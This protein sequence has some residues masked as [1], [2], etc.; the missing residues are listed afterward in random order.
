MIL[1]NNTLT[2]PIGQGEVVIF[3]DTLYFDSK[4]P[5]MLREVQEGAK[6]IGG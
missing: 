1:I 5:K 2:L 4:R 3:K 6:F